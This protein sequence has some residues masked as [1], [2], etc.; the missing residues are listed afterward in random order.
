MATTLQEK[1]VNSVKAHKD[2]CTPYKTLNALIMKFSQVEAGF[3][4]CREV[5][6]D[7]DRDNSG[8]IDRKELAEAVGKLDLKVPGEMIDAV[9]DESDLDKNENI[10]FKEFVVTLSILY[11]IKPGEMKGKA[12]NKFEAAVESVIN[13]FHFFDKNGDGMLEK[14]EV[15]SAFKGQDSAENI[16]S[17]RFEE[18]DWDHNGQ[19][20]FVEFMFAFESWVGL[21]DEE[22]EE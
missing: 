13:A 22:D 12:E 3:Q 1:L 4:A 19:I 16:F 6:K 5:F 14:E 21:E 2:H 8:A 7:F 20:S 17:T 9:F 18:M 15:M 10:S 11:L